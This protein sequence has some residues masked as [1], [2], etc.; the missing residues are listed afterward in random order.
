MGRREKLIQRICARPPQAR[1]SEVQQLLE[2]EGY[3]LH[4]TSGS[5]NIF[6]KP[7]SPNI[8]IPTVQGRMVKRTYLSMLCEDLGLDEE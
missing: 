5:H 4:R 2:I 8:T 1:F 6:V 3:S 7:N